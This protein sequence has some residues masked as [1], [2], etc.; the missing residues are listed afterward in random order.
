MNKKL[1]LEKIAEEIKNC[2]LCKKDKI[3]VAVPG[4]GNPDT[5]I[6]LIGEAPGKNEA[7]EGRP[8]I[9]RS[10]KYL[11]QVLLEIGIDPKDVFITSPVK[12]LPIHVT[13]T[14]EEIKHGMIHTQKQLDVINP[15]IIVLMGAT[16]A[17]GVLGEKIQVLKRHGEEIIKNG[18]KYLVVLHP[19]YVI[20]FKRA[21]DMFKNDFLKL[22]QPQL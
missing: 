8:F 22:K 17:R 19:A 16:A 9:G 12:Y 2:K 13:P 11:R 6:V 1:A 4:E 5:K 7:K 3:G 10:G 21:R 18:R 20:R 14:D 15:K